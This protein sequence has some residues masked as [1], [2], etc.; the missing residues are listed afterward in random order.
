[1]SSEENVSV[2]KKI[3]ENVVDV[4]DQILKI[5]EGDKK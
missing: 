3:I 1:M 5:G 4:L 2:P